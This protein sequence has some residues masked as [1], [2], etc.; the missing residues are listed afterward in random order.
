MYNLGAKIHLW[1]LEIPTKDIQV[2]DY[3]ISTEV[4]LKASDTQKILD[5]G[6]FIYKLQV[7]YA[8]GTGNRMKTKL[9]M[10]QEC[11]DCTLGIMKKMKAEHDEYLIMKQFNPDMEPR[12]NLSTFVEQEIQKSVKGSKYGVLIPKQLEDCYIHRRLVKP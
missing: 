9:P 4:P 3:V 10:L 8:K 7:S 2:L 1:T 12:T 5:L 6:N 11:I